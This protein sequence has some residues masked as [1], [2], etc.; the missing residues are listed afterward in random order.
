MYD[1]VSSRSRAVTCGFAPCPRRCAVAGHRRRVSQ[2][3]GDTPP[4]MIGGGEGAGRDQRC[5]AGEGPGAGGI[6]AYGGSKAWASKL[7]A[8][9]DAE[10]EAAF[11]PRSK[12]PPSSPTATPQGVVD[13]IL[14][15]RKTLA[16]QG[17]DAGPHTIG[18]HLAGQQTTVSVATISRILTRHGAVIPDPGKRPKRSYRRFGHVPF[19]GGVRARHRA[20]QCV[21]MMP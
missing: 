19:S 9:Y 12:R 6:A 17:L 15:L 21:L 14:A 4:V 3:I 8:R 10:G 11:E 16:E 13:R 20:G 2:A 5:P 18:W 1:S 7:L